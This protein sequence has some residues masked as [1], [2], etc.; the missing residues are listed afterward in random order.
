MNNSKK[1]ALVTK[2]GVDW[3]SCTSISNNLL[4]SYEASGHEL[5][6]F[7][8]PMYGEFPADF[9]S[10][11]KE[12]SKFNPDAVVFA[13]HGEA[14]Y[15]LLS[16]Y[17]LN[18][19][20]KDTEFI[21]HIYGDFTF[22][23][24]SWARALSLLEG[25]RVKL[26]CASEAQCDVV[27]NVL[28]VDGDMVRKLPFSVDPSE[29]YYSEELRENFRKKHGLKD[30]E[31]VIFYTGRVSLQKNVVYLVECFVDFCKKFGGEGTHLF[32]AGPCDDIGMPYLQKN[33]MVNF[34]RS[35]FLE[36]IEG[37]DNIHYL[38][39]LNSSELNE[40]ACGADL[41]CSLSVHNDEDYGMA[42]A[43]AFMTG[44]LGALTN[45]GGYKDFISNLKGVLPIATEIKSD[46]IEVV[47]SQFYKGLMKQ[48]D[49]PHSPE[50]RKKRGEDTASIFGVEKSKVNVKSI[51]DEESKR[52][53]AL[54]EKISRYAE[55]SKDG[56]LFSKAAFSDEYFDIY[57]GKYD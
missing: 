31:K 41:Y 40:L 55:K 30:N 50:E 5:S 39:V 29:F 7:D 51:I 20:E 1:I 49:L 47:T 3:K 21:F 57:K 56:R 18:N 13:D 45:W 52:M 53:P 36:S 10:T 8:I 17:L 48:L 16:H 43:E 37:A 9:I 6:Y 38:G 32:I 14:P 4:K 25:K 26:I 35:K 44:C 34:Y 12:I 2:K 11:S 42:P 33:L 15:M 46:S 23:L 54:T 27:K 28:E 19:S 22:F 24:D